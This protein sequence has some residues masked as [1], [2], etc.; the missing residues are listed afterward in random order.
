MF[1]GCVIVI[2]ALAAGVALVRTVFQQWGWGG[3]EAVIVVA[4]AI[5][6]VALVGF[7]HPRL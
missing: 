6:L 5:T 2:V 1:K 3:E 4:A 7:N